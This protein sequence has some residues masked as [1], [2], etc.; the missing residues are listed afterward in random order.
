MDKGADIPRS[1]GVPIFLTDSERIPRLSR[2]DV[3]TIFLEYFG[4]VFGSHL[5]ALRTG[6]AAFHYCG[7]NGG[8]VLFE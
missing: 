3:E 7:G 4:N 2:Q 6:F 8:D 1:Q 5:F